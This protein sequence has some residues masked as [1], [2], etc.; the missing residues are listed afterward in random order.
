MK[1]F[2]VNVKEWEYDFVDSVAVLA[3]D[4]DKAI[5]LAIEYDDF[6]KNNIGEIEEKSLTKESVVHQST[7][8][9]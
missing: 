5:E 2:I 4:K 1:L 9:G 6:F 7:I 8:D 3:K